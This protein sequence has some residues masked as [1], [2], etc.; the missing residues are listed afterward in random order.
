MRAGSLRQLV[1]LQQL[2]AGTDDGGGG[3]AESPDNE[4]WSDFATLYAHVEPLS[5]RELFQAQQIN[6]QL[7][8]RITVRYYPGVLSAMRV[9]YGTRIFIIE[10]IIDVDERHR[11]IQLMTRELVA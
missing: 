9:K 10:S 2:L 5:G 11:E 6:D 4:N 1:T 8:H 7:T 3:I